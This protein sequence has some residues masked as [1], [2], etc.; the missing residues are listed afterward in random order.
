[1]KHATIFFFNDT[2]EYVITNEEPAGFWKK[3]IIIL[4]TLFTTIKNMFVFMNNKLRLLL[5]LCHWPAIHR[6]KTFSACFII[7]KWLSINYN[8]SSLMAAAIGQFSLWS[9]GIWMCV[10]CTVYG[11]QQLGSNCSIYSY[12]MNL[13]LWMLSFYWK[14]DGL[15]SD[16]SIECFFQTKKKIYH[17]L[18]VLQCI[19]YYKS[20]VC[21][22]NTNVNS[23]KIHSVLKWTTYDHKF[24][25]NKTISNFNW[26]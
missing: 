23:H 2:I 17:T 16:L 14:W 22:W 3:L 8:G 12:K 7:I 24:L 25:H 9:Y 15:W 19:Y 13:L 1:M 26:L 5:F 10:W 6:S 20:N 4:P 18:R 21:N 11:T